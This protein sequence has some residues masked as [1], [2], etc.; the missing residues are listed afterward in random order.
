V[1]RKTVT[2][3]AW[4]KGTRDNHRCHDFL[5][6]RLH[7]RLGA[8]HWHVWRSACSECLTDGNSVNNWRLQPPLGNWTKQVPPN[9]CGSTIY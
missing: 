7:I 2:Q 8:S 6:P 9:G 4:R 3:N 5:W 1:H